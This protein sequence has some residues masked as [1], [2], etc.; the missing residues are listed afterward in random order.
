[1]KRGSAVVL[2][3]TAMAAGILGALIL[4]GEEG[5]RVCADQASEL[6]VDDRECEPEHGHYHWYYTSPNVHAA[7][8]GDRVTGGSYAKPSGS[9]AKAP[10]RGGFGSRGG[11]GGG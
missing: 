10:V 6:R 5:R 2:G 1:M 11:F 7:P 9:F 8:V 4:N 3:I